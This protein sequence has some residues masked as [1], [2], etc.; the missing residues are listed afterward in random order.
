M[1]NHKLYFLLL[2][3][4]IFSFNGKQIF[5]GNL[6]FLS[7]QNNQYI[8]DNSHQ[9]MM[10]E[11]DGHHGHK[12]INIPDGVPIP[13]VDLIVHKDAI[14]GWNLEVIVDNFEFEPNQ[15]NNNSDYRKGHAHIYINGKKLTRL[16]GNWFYL[17]SLPS[18]KNEI[19]I[20]LNTNKHENL[21]YKGKIISVEKI[22]KVSPE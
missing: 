10:E 3:S 15:A 1:K 9:E 22:I 16:Y 2:L 11:N 4:F 18:G 13:T 17:G 6:S 19:K 7:S 20:T 14:K 5:A 21:M 8:S 12:M